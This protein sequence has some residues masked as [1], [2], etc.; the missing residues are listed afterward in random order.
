MR[1]ACPDPGAQ[2]RGSSGVESIQPIVNIDNL[3]GKMN[4][5]GLVTNLVF[6]SSVSP[7]SPM[8][9]MRLMETEKIMEANGTINCE[10]TKSAQTTVGYDRCGRKA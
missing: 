3:A 4:H 8:R 7:V 10:D 6:G 5:F 2:L 1:N 9:L